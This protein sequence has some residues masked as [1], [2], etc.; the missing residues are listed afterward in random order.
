MRTLSALRTQLVAALA[1]SSDERFETVVACCRE[2]RI[3]DSRAVRTRLRAIE[4][5][6]VLRVQLQAAMTASMLDST[7][8][9]KVVTAVEEFLE[10]CGES[11]VTADGSTHGTYAGLSL[12]N[13]ASASSFNQ[14]IAATSE[15]SKSSSSTT[16]V[17]PANVIP[18]TGNHAIPGE[19]PARNLAELSVYRDQAS[20]LLH[21]LR[22]LE[23][24]VAHGKKAHAQMFVSTDHS[25]T[26]IDALAKAADEMTHLVESLSGCVPESGKE[27]LESA[28]ELLAKWRVEEGPARLLKEAMAGTDCERLRSAISA[29][30]DAGVGTKAAKKR[31]ARLELAL[32]ASA[33]LDAAISSGDT[34]ALRA[35]IAGARNADIDAGHARELLRE[36]SARDSARLQLASACSSNRED[37]IAAAIPPAK[38]KGVDTSLAEALLATL[39]EQRLSEAKQREDARLARRQRMAEELSQ[40][41]EEPGISARELAE[42]IRVARSGGVDVTSALLVLKRRLE[43]QVRVAMNAEPRNSKQLAEAIHAAEGLDTFGLV[44][45]VA[46]ATSRLEHWHKAERLE[47]ELRR[48]V[49]MV[50]SCA[51]DHTLESLQEKLELAR[52]DSFV[53]AGRVKT[54]EAALER[55]RSVARVRAS[56]RQCR[57]AHEQACM[58]HP[59][60]EPGL[61]SGVPEYLTSFRSELESVSSH[62]PAEM[63]GDMRRQAAVW[64]HEAELIAELRHAMATRDAQALQSAIARTQKE[65]AGINLEPPKRGLEKLMAEKEKQARQD[66]LKEAMSNPHDCVGLAVAIETAK[67]VGVPTYEAT[68]LLSEWQAHGKSLLVRA[69]TSGQRDRLRE[70]LDVAAGMGLNDTNEFVEARRALEDLGRP[71]AAGGGAAGSA[72][73][74]GLRK[75]FQDRARHPRYKTEMCA[76]WLAHGACA[77]GK[78]RCNFAHGED[79]LR[80]V[81]SPQPTRPRWTTGK[82]PAS[83]PPDP[84]TAAASQ[85]TPSPVSSGATLPH[86]PPV[87]NIP[88][89]AHSSYASS[90]SAGVFGGTSRSPLLSAAQVVVGGRNASD[91]ATAPSIPLYSL[92][93]SP[94]TSSFSNATLR[95]A[96]SSVVSS[97]EV[98]VFVLCACCLYL[99]RTVCAETCMQV[100]IYI[101]IC[102]CVCLQAGAGISPASVTLWECYPCYCVRIVKNEPSPPYSIC[103]SFLGH[104]RM[105]YQA[106][107]ASGVDSSIPRYNSFPTDVCILFLYRIASLYFSLPL[108]A[109]LFHF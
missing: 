49:A 9:Q 18:I 37:L 81:S 26:Y 61:P 73:A 72:W 8:L 68:V 52:E 93:S 64:A 78:E 53:D 43:E 39:E 82:G 25:V 13:H 57:L 107:S 20:E 14:N 99:L 3:Q 83:L 97:V 66:A 95:P 94:S 19:Q 41:A 60:L 70:A 71:Q 12:S 33:E 76:H 91:A 29:A 42:K 22:T 98:C 108:S 45:D 77:Y 106:S 35:A 4:Q 6:R 44:A 32:S 103:S 50:N 105:V 89:T 92:S 36:W 62:V 74:T 86:A 85:P 30:R 17:S 5:P 10:S 24:V 67:A 88:S 11:D 58:M 27:N 34:A 51:D 90:T 46:A 28:H 79:D 38:A 15:S 47:E 23:A 59:R 100:R 84:A 55:G 87:P 1:D 109:D 40:T 21:M 63:Q 31:L 7:A 69:V 65:G 80:H 2:A 101:Y 56:L 54:A 75:D 104:T 16:T 96:S 48:A 102:L